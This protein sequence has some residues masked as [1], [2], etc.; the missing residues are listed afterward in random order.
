M[1]LLTTMGLGIAGSF[2]GGFLAS[3]LA[4][5]RVLDFHTTG[6]IGSVLGAIVVLAVFGAVSRRGARA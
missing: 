3:I 1:G 2:T 6:L 5:H 4:G